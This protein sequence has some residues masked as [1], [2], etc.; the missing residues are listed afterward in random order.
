MP[1]PGSAPQYPGNMKDR[2]R[3]LMMQQMH[4]R[5]M[6]QEIMARQGQGQGSFVP[7]DKHMQDPSRLHPSMHEKMAAMN[8]NGFQNPSSQF[9]PGMMDKGQFPRTQLPT[10]GQSQVQ[11]GYPSAAGAMMRP[12]GP[13][14]FQRQ[15]SQPTPQSH[16]QYYQQQ[17]AQLM[18]QRRMQE[19]LQQQQH[20]QQSRHAMYPHNQ[21]Q[22]PPTSRTPPH[23]FQQNMN[24]AKLSSSHPSLPNTSMTHI[25]GQMSHNNHFAGMTGMAK[26]A[27]SYGSDGSRGQMDPASMPQ[28]QGPFP[29]SSQSQ[30]G[31]QSLPMM[32]RSLSMSSMHYSPM[33]PEARV[34]AG[35]PQM[36]GAHQNIEPDSTGSTTTSGLGNVDSGDIDPQFSDLFF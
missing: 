28:M 26:P 11:P 15:F 34:F 27:P 13:P 7:P 32:Q 30:N 36:M 23:N 9:Y 6:E 24:T 10:N 18:Y 3:L 29:Q 1:D 21:P 20:Q 25:P 17:Q 4:R 22:F 16:Q 5:R 14:A 12:G 19:Q 33:S 8:Y 31:G 35:S 2:M